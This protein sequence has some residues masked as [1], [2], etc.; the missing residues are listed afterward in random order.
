[1]FFRQQKAP[2]S[3][4]DLPIVLTRLTTNTFFCFIVYAALSQGVS[5]GKTCGVNPHRLAD[6]FFVKVLFVFRTTLLDNKRIIILSH[7]LIVA[8][9]I[10]RFC[11]LALLCFRAR[12]FGLSTVRGRVSALGLLCRH[13]QRRCRITQ[14]GIRVVGG[15]YRRLG[16][17]VTTLHRVSDTPTS[18]RL[19]TR[20]S[21]TRGT[22][23]LCST[24]QGANG[25]IL[26]IILARGDLLYRSHH[27]RLGTIASNDYLD[28]F[29]T[30][31]LCTLFT[32]VLSR[33][34]RDTIGI[35]RPRHHYVSLLIYAQRDFIIIGIV[36]PSHPTRSTSAHTTRCTIGIAGHVIRG[37]GNALAARDRGKFFTIGVVFPDTLSIGT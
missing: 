23:R 28:F 35:P 37:C 31:S 2:L 6:T 8:V 12:I 26:S 9:F 7:D 4:E 29:R 10:K 30:D 33:T 32:G 17:R 20:V 18:P 13:R 21:R 5:C 19:G 34:V 16:L 15:H 22:T 3:L 1:M 24:D 25:R 36:D 14:R 27:V 11:F